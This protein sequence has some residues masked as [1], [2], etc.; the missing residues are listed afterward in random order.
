VVLPV[1]A[2]CHRREESRPAPASTAPS[3]SPPSAG[4]SPQAG[5]TP[6]QIEMKNVRLHFDVDLVLDVRY[7]RGEMTSRIAG[8]PPVFDDPR[9]YTI[10]VADADTAIDMTNLANLLNHHV[11]EYDGAPLRDVSLRVDA[12]GHLEQKGKLHK[13]VTLP[14]SMKAAVGVS[15][16][17]RM[18]LDAQSIK[19]AGLPSKGLL[20]FI[21]LSLADVVK[22]REQRGVEIQGDSLLIAPGQVLPPPEMRGRL[23]SV[24][25]KNNTLV[26]HF[27]R[28]ND[29]PSSIAPADAHAQNYLYFSGG[30]LRFGKLTMTAADLELIDADPS[31][32]FDFFPAKYSEQLT[33]GYSLT[34]A[35]GGLRTYMPDY[36]DAQ[37]GRQ[38]RP[39]KTSKIPN[40]A[41][42]GNRR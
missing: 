18:R 20:D 5:V 8:Q 40:P 23:T 28:G 35:S 39:P 9:S 7:L 1:V 29:H 21:G 42:T 3:P 30:V 41:R 14:F 10:Q 22:L 27:G 31:D 38:A 4:G 25:I 19:V 34:T 2:G 26:Q 13:G 36:D 17:G 11:F 37:A 15:D 12:E 6:V 24:S 33:A 16:D 32:P